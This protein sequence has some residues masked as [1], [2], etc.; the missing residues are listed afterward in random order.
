MD[1][2]VIINKLNSL[3]KSILDL[4]QLRDT[5]PTL[6]ISEEQKKL[7]TSLINSEIAS[8]KSL[9]N[10]IERDTVSHKEQDVDVVKN[11][12]SSKRNK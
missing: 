12:Y 6:P 1:Y 5:V 8:K 10:H 9:V 11:G 7:M 3:K 2:F 4:E